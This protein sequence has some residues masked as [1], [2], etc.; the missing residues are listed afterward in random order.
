MQ[1]AGCRS[2]S[3]LLTKKN[4]R[5]TSRK[6]EVGSRYCDCLSC[7]EYQVSSIKFCSRVV[8]FS[9]N[10][11]YTFS[12]YAFILHPVEFILVYIFR[13]SIMMYTYRVKS[14]LVYVRSVFKTHGTLLHAPLNPTC[15]SHFAPDRKHYALLPINRQTRNA[16]QRARRERDTTLWLSPIICPDLP[17]LQHWNHTTEC[18]RPRYQSVFVA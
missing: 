9:E 7:I 10:P 6:Y 12:A 2:L 1:D 8:V 17:S 16:K 18:C 11:L 15:T 13:R 5:R 14:A 3:A 4:S